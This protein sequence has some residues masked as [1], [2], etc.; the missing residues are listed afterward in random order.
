MLGEGKV[1]ELSG[2]DLGIARMNGTPEVKRGDLVL[3]A[4]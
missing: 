4:E 3:L 1:E 2:E